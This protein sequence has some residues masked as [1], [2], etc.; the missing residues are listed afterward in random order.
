MMKT[1]VTERPSLAD[2]KKK[3]T[4]DVDDAVMFCAE[5]KGGAMS[6]VRASRNATGRP[7]D[8]RI[9]IDAENGAIIHDG[10]EQSIRLNLQKGPVRH[11]GW[12][13]LAI[14][15][16]YGDNTFENEVGHV[17]D[18]IRSGETRCRVWPKP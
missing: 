2:P 7:D 13:E 9:E 11:A 1:F 3:E 8:W 14:P 4:V 10:L 15:N 6:V 5:F 17:M 16:R 18:C 12:V